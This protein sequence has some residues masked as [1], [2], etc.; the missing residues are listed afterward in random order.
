[1]GRLD[2]PDRGSVG[3][4]LRTADGGLT[5]DEV[6]TNV[7]PGLNAVHFFDDQQGL[8]CGDG[9][10]AFPGGVFAT[11]DGGRTWRPADGGG[12]A[13]RGGP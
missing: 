9:S 5:W 10:D 8:V 7:L 4:L 12:R 11:A 6:G 1:M 2:Q 13:R 3:V